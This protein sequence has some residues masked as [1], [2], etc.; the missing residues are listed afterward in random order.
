MAQLKEILEI[1]KK[2]EE[3]GQYSTIYLFPPFSRICNSGDKNISICNAENNDMRLPWYF[4]KL[5]NHTTALQPN[6]GVVGLSH[7]GSRRINCKF[8]VHLW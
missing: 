3:G 6:G 1:E 7:R 8:V 4:D 2:R 5:S